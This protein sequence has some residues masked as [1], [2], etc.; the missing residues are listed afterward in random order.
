MPLLQLATLWRRRRIKAAVEVEMKC[1]GTRE[2]GV[3]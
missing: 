1:F 2:G 3:N